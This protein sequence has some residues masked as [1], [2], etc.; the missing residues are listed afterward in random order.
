MK[1][2]SPADYLVWPS[3]AQRICF[4]YNAAPH[5][6]LT[7]VSPFEMDCGTLPVSTFAP[8]EL[9]PPP[10]LDDTAYDDSQQGLK[11]PAPLTPGRRR[12]PSLRRCFSPL[13][14][15]PPRVPTAD[16]GRTS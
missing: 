6:S 13:R 1:F 2:L 3:F 15:L 14:P 7:D 9:N 12:Y 11:P 8:P 4:A 16:N 10:P 5:A